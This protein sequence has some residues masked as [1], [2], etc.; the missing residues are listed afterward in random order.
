M[1]CAPPECPGVAWCEDLPALGGP[2]GEERTLPAPLGVVWPCC[3]S[4]C[5]FTSFPLFWLLIYVALL[6][7]SLLLS[8]QVSTCQ[9][10][11]K[12]IT[13]G[14]SL[15]QE[16]AIERKDKVFAWSLNFVRVRLL[17]CS[18]LRLFAGAVQLCLACRLGTPANPVISR[19]NTSSYS[20]ILQA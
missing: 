7:C 9:R 15:A 16:N 1:L 2:R 10:E 8:W 3:W 13:L 17:F 18:W 11:G 14:A 6:N 5:C 19:L 20:F 4:D 12:E